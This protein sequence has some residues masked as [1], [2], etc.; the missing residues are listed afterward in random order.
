ML[1]TTTQYL[2][3]FSILTSQNQQI[4]TITNERTLASF[5]QLVFN[6]L[7]PANVATFIELPTLRPLQCC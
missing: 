2:A 3:W 4:T 5:S 1:I 7:R 6:H